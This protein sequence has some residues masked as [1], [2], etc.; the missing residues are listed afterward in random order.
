LSRFKLY[1]NPIL[2]ITI[3]DSDRN[4]FQYLSDLIYSNISK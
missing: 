3:I 4:N 2:Q 1:D